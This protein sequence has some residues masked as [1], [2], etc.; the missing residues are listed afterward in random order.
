MSLCFVTGGVR[1]GKSAFAE[2][3]AFKRG[4]RVLYIAT[5]VNTDDEMNERIR[6]HKQRRPAS[7]GLVEEPYDLNKTIDTYA[8]YD[9]ILI[10]CLSTLVSNHLVAPESNQ[11]VDS[12]LPQWL[13]MILK[14]EASFIVVSNEVGL[15]GVAMSSLGR[16]FQDQLGKANQL[17]A[18]EADEA[19]AVF[20]GIP[21]RLK[22]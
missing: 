3:F 14:M 20:S 4:E 7:W 16:A 1:S 9:V 15:G 19:Y 22:P 13:E 21:M 5:G 2:E 10:D 18:T 12:T 11:S 17:V 6:A 8:K